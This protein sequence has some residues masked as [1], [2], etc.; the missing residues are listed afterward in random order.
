VTA[1][2]RRPD[3]SIIT[4]GHDVADARLHRIVAALRRQDASVEVLGLGDAEGGPCGAQVRTWR[5]P[6]LVGR[7]LLAARLG[8]LARGRVLLTLDPDAL[9]LAGPAAWLRRRR[10]V[11]D[12]HEDYRSLLHDRPWASGAVGRVAGI[13][14]WVAERAAARSTL[15]IV[16]DEHV[17][18]A[19]ARQRMVVRNEPDTSMLPPAQRPGPH[20]RAAYVG[21]VRASRGLF[22]ML[23]ALAAAPGWSLDVVGPVAAA[24]RA[25]L[26]ARLAVDPALAARITWHG[27]L[28]PV[29]A[30]QAVQGAWAG[31]CLLQ[32]TPAFRESVPS[33]LYEYL[34][35]GLV[36][37]ATDLPRQRALV[38]ES[39]GGR[40]VAGGA[41]AGECLRQLEADPSHRLALRERGLAWSQSRTAGHTAYDDA[42][43]RLVE[44][45]RA[46]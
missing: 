24:D 41:E 14:A 22:A 2:G 26:D 13:L 34:A 30:W 43:E 25:A 39:G 5:R 35:A 17:P 16:A 27:R 15:T 21:D 46:R 29:A 11:A 6:G 19:R 8:W 12:V 3:V 4:S 20:P 10:L 37:I 1:G 38:E 33:K 7:A 45:A 40:V 44:L 23:D 36:P 31:L 32:D 18:P 42:A 28:H 9:V